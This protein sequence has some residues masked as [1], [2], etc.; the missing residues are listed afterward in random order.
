M[1]LSHTHTEEGDVSN[2]VAYLV[3]LVAEFPVTVHNFD[4]EVYISTSGSVVDLY[5]VRYY[6][7]TWLSE[8]GSRI[9]GITSSLDECTKDLPSYI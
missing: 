9:L 4:I 5:L 3:D 1:W 6:L 8:A 7:K 2:L